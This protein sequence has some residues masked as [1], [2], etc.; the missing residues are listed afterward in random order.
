MSRR[1]GARRV[2]DVEQERVADVTRASIG[3]ST[4]N[5]VVDQCDR[6]RC[7]DGSTRPTVRRTSARPAVWVRAFADTCTNKEPK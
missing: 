3:S 7:I 1:I 5:R 6:S 2:L 4:R